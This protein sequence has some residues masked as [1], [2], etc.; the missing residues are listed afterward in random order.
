MTSNHRTAIRILSLG[1]AAILLVGGFLTIGAVVNSAPAG[2]TS[3]TP[4]KGNAPQ[5]CRPLRIP[6][7][8]DFVRAGY[9]LGRWVSPNLQ[10]IGWSYQEDGTVYLSASCAWR[11]R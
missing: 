2:A 4:I 6:A 3:V 8:A 1:L 11:F 9:G 7:G 10:T 5:F